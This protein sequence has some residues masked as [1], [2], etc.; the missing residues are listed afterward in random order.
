MKKLKELVGLIGL[1]CFSLLLSAQSS[2][3]DKSAKKIYRDAESFY[4]YGDFNTAIRLFRQIETADPDFEEFNYKLGDAYFQLNRYD[5][6]AIFYLAKIELYNGNLSTSED[7]LNHFLTKKNTKTTVIS[8]VDIK[9]LNENIVTAKELMSIP[10]VVNIINLGSKINSENAE[11][12]PLISSDETFLAF[13][14]RRLREGNGLDPTGRP[15][16][17][18]YTSQR[19]SDREDW[20]EAKPIVGKI[21]TDQH[22]AC[23]GLSP[24]G[25]RLFIYRSNE[26]LIGG[27]LFESIYLDGIW[28][29]PV[30]MSDNINGEFSI[31]PSASL[32]L[33]ESV[34]YFSSNREGG[35]G[36]FDIYRVIKL[37]NGEWSLPKNLGPSINT[38]FDDDAPFI[39]PDGKMLYFSSKGHKNMGGYDVF[40]AQKIND[41]N[42]EWTKPINMGFP[43][44]TTKDDIYFTIS[45]NEQHGYY[46][47]NKAGGF[48]KHDIYLID[49]LEK[50]LRQSVVRGKVK[51]ATTKEEIAAD[52][53]V[54]ETESAELSGVYVAQGK[55]GKF[56]FLVNPNVEYEVIV[57]AEGFEE[58]SEFIKFS[59]NELK[60]TQSIDFELYPLEN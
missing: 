60:N 54:I 49:Y 17:D 23:V 44:N 14:S 24:D 53:S 1:I 46:A 35:F 39:H 21:N 19:E 9:L 41:E 13:T 45:A 25:N 7:Y 58:K 42:E 8:A 12:V 18:V 16:E 40:R 11:Y 22:D 57:E 32:S 33:D 3:Y 34:L 48:G 56:I 55:D 28:T 43:T 10:D 15:F 59:T 20:S 4:I 52:I 36:G 30:K 2:K 29:V 38:E 50:S 31:E 37:P 47:S 27:D 5:S 51:D 26:N 6:D